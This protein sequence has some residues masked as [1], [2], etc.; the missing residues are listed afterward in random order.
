MVTAAALVSL[1]ETEKWELRI[2]LG[3]NLVFYTRGQRV[4]E[5]NGAG[6]PKEPAG[7]RNIKVKRGKIHR[8]GEER[9]ERVSY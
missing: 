1:H 2:A 9:K 8:K 7:E 6:V 5:G 3:G 4:K